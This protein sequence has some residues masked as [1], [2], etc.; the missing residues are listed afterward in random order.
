MC[1]AWVAIHMPRPLVR[2]PKVAFIL[3]PMSNTRKSYV[4]LSH[5]RSRLGSVALAKAAVLAQR[6]GCGSGRRLAFLLSTLQRRA[7]SDY[8]NALQA[9]S[10]KLPR[11]WRRWS[12]EVKDEWLSEFILEYLEEASTLGPKRVLTAA[13]QKIGVCRLKVS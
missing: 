9:F 4:G 11:H 12:S 2:A 5:A 6:L 10:S 3:P 8:A 13:L 1:D 7:R